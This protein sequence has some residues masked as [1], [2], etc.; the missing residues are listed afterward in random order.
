MTMAID[1]QQRHL[2]SMAFD[3][4]PYPGPPH[5]TNPWAPTTSANT[6]SQL[7][8][9]SMAQNNLGLE[10]IAKQQAARASS[11]SMP[12]TSIPVT[13]PSISAGSSFPTVPYGQPGLLSLPQDLLNPARS[14]YGSESSYTSAPSPNPNA[15]APTSASYAP[16]SFTQSFQHQ[17]QQAHDSA[18]RLSQPSASSSSYLGAPV[19]QRQ[20]QN[21]LI[22][23]N[24]RS[25]SSQQSQHSFGDA[26]DAG[27]GMVAMSQD[28][29]PRN[30]YGPRSDRDSPD[31]YGFPSTH[32]SSSSISSASTYPS[33]F[34]SCA[35]SSVS[36]YSSASE[37]MEPISSRTLPRPSGLIG[38]NLPPAPQ[39]MMSQF[40]SKVSS[41]TQKKHKCKVCD[42]RFTR[43]SS[44]QTHMYSHTGEKRES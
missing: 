36:D 38:A 24:D 7:F 20:R 9:T 40:N 25:T 35:D 4:M 18:R 17:Q 12:Y 29:T 33:Y 5:F 43:P 44:L 31:S 8:P 30:I 32:S 3:H 21:S 22:D 15:Y 14:S 13:A 11:V 26:L 28:M 10:A 39:S 19:D 42:K 6:T 27:R 16:L 23:F 37:C 2:G 34:G 41:S 1:N